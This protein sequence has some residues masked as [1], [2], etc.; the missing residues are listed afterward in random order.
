M[1]DEARRVISALEGYQDCHKPYAIPVGDNDFDEDGDYGRD[2]RWSDYCL[3]DAADLI[4]RQASELDSKQAEIDRL[5]AENEQLKA[6]NQT[7]WF[8]LMGVMHSV[9]KWLDGVEHYSDI[10]DDD[11][12]GN[13]AVNRAAD[14]REKTLQY[15]EKQTATINR[16][17]KEL[18]QNGEV[19]EKVKAEL[20]EVKQE[21]AAAVDTLNKLISNNECCGVCKYPDS[22]EAE[23][24]CMK[25]EY[26]GCSGEW[27][28]LNR[29]WGEG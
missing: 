17:Q 12:N 11:K 7:K 26:G 6:E 23:T 21:R 19:T 22:L 13:I 25:D 2:W 5:T 18:D 16:L 8:T 10:I 1:T 14:A 9:D 4:E 15:M 28:G 24:K 27:D 29:N 3:D 20:A